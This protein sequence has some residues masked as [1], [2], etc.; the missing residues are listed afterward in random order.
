MK[1]TSGRP[2]FDCPTKT[3]G[4]ITFQD[5][6]ITTHQFQFITVITPQNRP[7][8]KSDHKAHLNQVQKCQRTLSDALVSYSR[9]ATLT[10]IF[11][12]V[13]LNTAK[14]YRKKS[15]DAQD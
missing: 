14:D 13:V 5:H 6:N 12:C 15:D 2:E 11:Q 7:F 9:S 1:N 4:R 3:M 8:P 10:D